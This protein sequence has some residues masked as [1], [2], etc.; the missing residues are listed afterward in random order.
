M[1]QITEEYRR[2][3]RIP[4]DA[5]AVVTEFGERVLLSG[6]DEDGKQTPEY[7][8]IIVFS[9]IVRLPGGALHEVPL[10]YARH[11]QQGD[12]FEPIYIEYS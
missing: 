12:R 5:I 1:A 8:D 11:I 2:Q 10:K 9:I 6:T 3:S 4:V 7:D